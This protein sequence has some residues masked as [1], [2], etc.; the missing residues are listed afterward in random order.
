MSLVA[1]DPRGRPSCGQ[2]KSRQLAVALLFVLKMQVISLC[3]EAEVVKLSEDVIPGA[4]L[5]KTLMA[6]TVYL[7][8]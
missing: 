8:N 2:K 1:R 5:R 7:A 6:L 4:C 3:M